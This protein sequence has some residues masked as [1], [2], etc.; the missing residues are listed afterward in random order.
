M[1]SS[2]KAILFECVCG[3]KCTSTSRHKSRCT[4]YKLYFEDCTALKLDPKTNI[5][6]YSLQKRQ[7]KILISP[8]TIAT[9]TPSPAIHYIQNEDTSSHNSPKKQKIHITV[10]VTDNVVNWY[11]N[12]PPTSPIRKPLL[13]QVS[14][15]MSNVEASKLFNV[16]P[17]TVCK[18]KKYKSTLL[19]LKYQQAQ[20]CAIR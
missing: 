7:F 1:P 5:H 4:Y 18:A 9:T 2:S 13:H 8:H 6:K 16:D 3:S 15:N 10:K 17:S 12:L 20:L 19:E 11:H 14:R